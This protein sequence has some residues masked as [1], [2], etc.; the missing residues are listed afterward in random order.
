MEDAATAE[1]SRAQ[2]WQWLRHEARL[3]DGRTI[4]PLLV[5]QTIASETERRLIRAGSVV[6]RIT[7][8]SELLEKFVLEPELSDFLTLDA[9]DKLVSVGK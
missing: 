1:I 8:A 5:K 4:D 3:E 2:L 9:Y 6:N 7:E